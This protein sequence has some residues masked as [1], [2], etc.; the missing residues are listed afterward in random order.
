[1]NVLDDDKSI[2]NKDIGVENIKLQDAAGSYAYH[3]SEGILLHFNPKKKINQSSN[4]NWIPISSLDF[5]PSL[6]NKFNKDVPSYMN[7]ENLFGN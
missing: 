1:M 4:R 6:L 3:I 7:N 2:S 5:A